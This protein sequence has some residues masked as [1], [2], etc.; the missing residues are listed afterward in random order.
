M[1]KR[2]IILCA[3]VVLTVSGCVVKSLHP[4]FT[5]KDLVFKKEL[6]GTWV[7]QDSSLWAISQNKN[8]DSLP[9]NYSI[10]FIEGEKVSKFTAHLFE[11]S[12]Q[13]Y[14]DFFP[15]DISEPELTKFHL[16]KT[17]SL[18]KIEIFEDSLKLK[19][20]NELWL[21]DLF[22]NNKIRISHEVIKDDDDS[23][24]LTAST[25]E[26]QKFIVKYGNDPNAFEDDIL[27]FTLKRKKQ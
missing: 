2:S 9:A 20:F 27:C 19:W 4:F 12:N 15:D 10:S 22:E 11:L 6:I 1:K 5:S 16:V 24:V 25:D 17:H 3:F 14:V 26:L 8:N 21:A 23:Y 18:V 13:L 7:D